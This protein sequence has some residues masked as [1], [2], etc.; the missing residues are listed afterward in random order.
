MQ[1]N[2]SAGAIISNGSDGDVEVLIFLDMRTHTGEKKDRAMR[3]IKT[4]YIYIWAICL[5]AS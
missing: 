3:G 5:I 1:L 2:Y 4:N